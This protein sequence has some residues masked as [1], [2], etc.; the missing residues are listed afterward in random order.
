MCFPSHFCTNTN[1]VNSLKFGDH[2]VILGDDGRIVSQGSFDAVR[3]SAYLESLSLEDHQ[4]VETRS[5]TD[6][7]DKASKTPGKKQ[8][9]SDVKENEE[10]L[11]RRAGD[12]SLYWYYL[13]SIGWFYG[14]LGAVFLVGEVLFRVFPRESSSPYSLRCNH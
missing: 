1:Q 10:D 7:G 5:D 13:K 14:I 2:I 4:R 6:G 8:K 11:L 9:P 3:R 12:T